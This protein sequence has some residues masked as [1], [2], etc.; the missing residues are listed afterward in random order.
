M[1]KRVLFWSGEMSAMQLG[2]RLAAA[3]AG[4]PV[5]DVFRGRGLE[6]PP[7]IDE[8]GHVYRDLTRAEW[9]SLVAAEKDA[10]NLPL[11]FDDRP[12]ITV[13]KLRTRARRM[14]RE[15]GGLALIVADY[16]GLMRA[17][18]QASRMGLREAYTE[19]SADLKALAAELGVPLVALSQLSRDVEKRDNKI[20]VMRDLRESGA[21]EQDAYGIMFLHRPHYYLV[22]DGEPV[23]GPKEGPEEFSLRV[24]RYFDALD[25]EKDKAVLMIAKNRSGATGQTKLFFEAH[26]T[27]FRGEGKGRA[28]G[29][30]GAKYMGA[31]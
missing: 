1:G 30:W 6:T 7:D 26:T 21:I 8:D 31:A 29:A 15:K 20:P 10:R 22:Q 16:L 4:L 25:R 2:T 13:A 14:A 11:Y 17:T 3:H 9:D 27:W 23:Q 24:S 19:I 12:A 5:L 18:A 28:D